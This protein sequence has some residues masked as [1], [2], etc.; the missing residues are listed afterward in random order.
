MLKR[1]VTN[2]VAP[3]FFV[4][5]STVAIYGAYLSTTKSLEF[6]LFESVRTLSNVTSNVAH[7]ARQTIIASRLS[8][9]QVVSMEAETGVITSSSGTYVTLNDNF[10]V[11]T[12]FHGI[13]GNCL[14]TKILIDEEMHNCVEFVLIDID[15]DYVAIQVEEIPTRTAVDIDIQVP[16]RQEW[17]EALSIMT[18]VYYTGFPNNTGP[19]TF[20]GVIIGYENKGAIFIDSYGWSGSSGSGVFTADGQLIGYV[21]ALEVGESRLGIQVL[22]NFVW[23]VPLY[24]VNWI[25][26]DALADK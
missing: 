20:D 24:N 11:L 25:A 1:V 10:F 2:I 7:D 6:P 23:V 4:L 17:R 12:T 18:P 26:I 21:L 3:L 8:S 15:T 5:L 14:T 22:E 13:L 19:L 9:V 16:H